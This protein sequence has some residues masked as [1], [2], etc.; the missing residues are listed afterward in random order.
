[1]LREADL[2]YAIR[3]SVYEVHRVLGPGFL[4]KVYER[5][6]LEELRRRDLHAALQ[7]PL[8]VRYK[9][10]LVGEYCADVVVEDRVLVEIKA[11]ERAAS[12]WQA[13]V[14]HYLRATGIR[15]GLLVNFG[16]PSA[17][18]RRFIL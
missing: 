4:E 14:L 1:M 13:Q 17:T 3:S 16:G 6:L 15:I 5:A 8:A 7:V 10:V 18:I 12:S 2:T 11:Q 9:G